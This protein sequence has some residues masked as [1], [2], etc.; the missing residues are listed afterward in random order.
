MARREADAVLRDLEAQV[1]IV[2]KATK[3]VGLVSRLVAKANYGRLARAFSRWKAQASRAA[4]HS[5]TQALRLVAITHLRSLLARV[6]DLEQAVARTNRKSG[7]SRRYLGCVASVVRCCAPVSHR[8]QPD[9]PP[10]RAYG[11]LAMDDEVP[12]L[13]SLR[14][15]AAEIL[16]TTDRP[17]RDK[18]VAKKKQAPKRCR[19]TRTT[20]PRTTA[21]PH[22]DSLRTYQARLPLPLDV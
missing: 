10:A 4:A 7:R 21:A 13:V 1:E 9:W 12:G 22:R 20:S 16:E 17:R 5:D 14:E 19:G 6:D 18:A 15:A 11:S 8:P 3:I 2:M